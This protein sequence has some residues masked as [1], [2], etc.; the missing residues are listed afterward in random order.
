MVYLLRLVDLSMAM[1]VISRWV[2]FPLNHSKFSQFFPYQR[3]NTWFL[4]RN[5]LV[6]CFFW[7]LGRSGECRNS[8]SGSSRGHLRS[9][10]CHC[11]LLFTVNPKQEIEKYI[12]IKLVGI[13]HDLPFHHFF[14][15]TIDD[16]V[17]PFRTILYLCM[18]I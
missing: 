5:R 11:L 9:M 13:Y 18:T 6:K 10:I 14:G 12:S 8:N 1:L 3:F 16:W 7:V 2:T 4:V 15:V 17:K